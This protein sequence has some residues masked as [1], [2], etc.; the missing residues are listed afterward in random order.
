LYF[1]TAS[2]AFLLPGGGEA[3]VCELAAAAGLQEV[4]R[5]ASDDSAGH[6]HEPAATVVIGSWPVVGM[7][8]ARLQRVAER[9]LFETFFRQGSIVD[10]DLQA[11]VPLEEDPL[12]PLAEAFRNA[13]LSLDAEAAWL[14]TATLYGYPD[15]RDRRGSGIRNRELA[16]LVLAIEV[17][18]LMRERLTLLYLSDELVA[19]WDGEVNDHDVDD[20]EILPTPRGLIVFGHR[21]S[22][23]W[24]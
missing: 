11:D 17:D 24:L 9:P 22:R 21:G 12:F 10:A 3:A 7:T 8:W 14:D 5:E 23:R 1:R 13:C 16:E 6:A 15:W 4:R 20:H 19:I 18:A 2:A